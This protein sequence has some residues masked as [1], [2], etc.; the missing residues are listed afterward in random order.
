MPTY[1]RVRGSDTWHWCRN[2]SRDPTAN[3]ETEQ[4]TGKERPRGD[5]CN[6]CKSKEANDNCR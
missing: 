2:C 1:R 3:Y 4:K 6:E 5:L